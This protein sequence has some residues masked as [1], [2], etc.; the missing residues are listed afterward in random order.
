MSER[1]SDGA[2]PAGPAWRGPVL[3]GIA[4]FA[5]YALVGLGAGWMWHELWQPSEGVVFQKIWYPGGEG[6]R[7]DFSGTGLYVLVAAGCGLALGGVFAWVGGARPVLTLVLCVAA[8]LL[9]G[10]LMLMLG[11]QLGPPD[12]HELAKTADDGTRLPSALQVA[13]LPPLF[14]FSL[15]SLAALAAVFTLF[16]GKTAEAGFSAEPRR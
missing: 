15:G 10:W 1:V 6:L 8:S 14:A 3:L 11:E 4:I 5:V 7:E 13:G 12:P 2:E 16:P 9:A